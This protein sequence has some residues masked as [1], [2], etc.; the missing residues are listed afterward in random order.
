MNA[1][2]QI[3]E[4]LGA[5]K[6]NLLEGENCEISHDRALRVL[7]EAVIQINAL[8]CTNE[9]DPVFDD[10]FAILN[11]ETEGKAECL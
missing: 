9:G 4:W 5:A 11:D 2:V 3:H 10:F 1:Y 8:S 6:C 7:S